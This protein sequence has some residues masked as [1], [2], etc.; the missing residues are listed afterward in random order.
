MESKPQVVDARGVGGAPDQRS[1][2]KPSQECGTASNTAQRPSPPPARLRLGRSATPS[3]PPG[4]RRRTTR[5]SSTSRPRSRSTANVYA[6]Q[7]RWMHRHLA[8][9]DSVMLSPPTPQRPRHRRRRRRL[10]LM[11]GADRVEAACSATAAHRQRR[12][13][14]LAL[15]LYYTRACRPGSTSRHQRGRAHR[16]ALQ[17]VAHPPTPSLRGDLV[18]WPSPAPTRTP[19]SGIR[20][21]KGRRTRG[22]CPTSRSTPPTSAAATTP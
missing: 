20:R 7:V 8:R 6:D 2:R 17:P 21:S 4:A 10:G 9:R 12:S 19:S 14:H 16:R 15:N 11:A 18:F 22:T 3:P 5:S 13:R 1:A